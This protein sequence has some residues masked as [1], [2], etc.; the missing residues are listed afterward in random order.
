MPNARQRRPRGLAAGRLTVVVAVLALAGLPMAGPVRAAGDF[1]LLVTPSELLLPPGG[2]VSFL[3]SVGSVGGFSAPV[4]LTLDPLPD[5]VSSVLSAETVTPPATVHLTLTASEDAQIGSFQLVLH[6]TGGGISH[7]ANGSVTVDFGLVP[8]CYASIEGTVRDRD[9]GAPIEGARAPSPEL[10]DANGHYASGNIGLGENNS[11]IETS[12]Q[13]SKVGYWSSNE[14]ATFVC[15][16]VTHLDFTLLAWKPAR[17]HGIVVEGT[18]D[19]DNPTVVVPGATPIGGIT[20]ASEGQSGGLDVSAAGGTFGFEVPFLGFENAP[21]PLSLSAGAYPM[22]YW[23]RGSTTPSPIPIGEVAPG[24][25]P[26]VTIGLVRACTTRISGEVTYGDT[27]LPAAGAQVTAG[28]AWEQR[29]TTTDAG[30]QFDFP[31]VFLGYNNVPVDV[32]IDLWVTTGFYVTGSGITH[33]GSCG[34][35]EI[36]NVVLPPIPFGTVRGHVTDIE[37]SEPIVGAS[38][39]LGFSC[40]T[41]APYPSIT[42]A[43]GAY[44][45]GQIP[46]VVDVPIP[47]FVEASKAEYWLERSS[48]D[49]S[50][51]ETVTRDLKLLR[52][53]YAGLTGT[54]RDAITHEPIADAIGG[55]LSASPSATTDGQGRYSQ[56]HLSLGD[57]NAPLDSTVTFGKPGYW[58]ATA[59]ITLR[60]D[61]TSMADLELLPICA[62]A[63]VR[64]RSSMRA[65]SCPSPARWCLPLVQIRR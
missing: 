49:L 52:V 31:A 40:L 14:S 1:Q 3:V 48:F 22:V 44:L 10:T 24:D 33:V 30:G 57:H 36:V 39:D 9:T 64:E 15:D 12:L 23:P 45:I 6:A 41:C 2:S 58:P 27:N 63:T 34:G 51:G 55:A 13:S 43:T 26:V 4:S 17:V 65:P 46:T 53:R 29:T 28:H 59:P 11:P 54:V 35:H 8:V 25:D 19:P 47:Y 18:P 32:S 56:T 21:T 7:D 62:G 60:A 16:Q 37:T 42:D 50:P 61:E 20:V 5:G 38:V